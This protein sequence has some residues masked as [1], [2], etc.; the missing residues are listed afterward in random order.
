MFNY[1]YFI[2]VLGRLCQQLTKLI[3]SELISK[4]MCCVLCVAV[5]EG[6]QKPK[7]FNQRAYRTGHH[8]LHELHISISIRYSWQTVSCRKSRPLTIAVGSKAK[9]L[10]SN[11]LIGYKGFLFWLHARSLEGEG[12]RL[13]S[14]F[15]LKLTHN[16]ESG[17]TSQ[18]AA[19]NKQNNTRPKNNGEPGK[20]TL[21]SLRF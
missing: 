18:I 2:M 6:N 3:C 19:V 4:W 13:A 7:L 9:G 12:S 20:A 21:L 8:A 1:S 15:W 11:H 16:E 17:T 10:T 14:G 5:T